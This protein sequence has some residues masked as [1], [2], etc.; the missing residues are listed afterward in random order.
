MKQVAGSMKLDLAQFREME[1]FAQFGSDLDKATQKLLNRGRRLTELLKQDQYS[2]M[3]VE[4]QVAV[5]FAGTQGYLDEVD[6]GRITRF[7][8][9]FLTHIRAKHQDLLDRIRTDGK[10]T[11]E[12]E[13]ELR[14]VID[15]F[16]KN[17]A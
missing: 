14:S 2:P 3:P 15:S 17:F 12:S 16:V 1:A 6:I 11:D 8:E 7:E 13:S 10:L 5:I 4:E 9:E